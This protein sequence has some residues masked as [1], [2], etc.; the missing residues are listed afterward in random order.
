MA[1][2]PLWTDKAFPTVPAPDHIDVK[3]CGLTGE[4][5]VS[6]VA[7]AR[8]DFAGFVFF[9]PSPRH[10][11]TDRAAALAAPLR[12]TVKTVALT[13]DAD[14]QAF[15]DIFDRFGPDML[16]LHGHESPERVA[17]LKDRYRVPVMK[18]IPVREADDLKA[19]DAYLDV[20]DCILF[21]AKAPKG[22]TRPGGLGLSFDW[23]LLAGLD[24]PVPFMLSGGLDAET[25]A[26]AIGI[27][28]P[29]AVD[30]S[31][32]VESA[33]GAKDPDAIARF[34]AAVRSSEQ[35]PD[36]APDRPMERIPS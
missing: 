35:A 29:D 21:D 32:G 31:S 19:A 4:A 18:M 2:I 8:V 34:V 24:L 20:A 13:V 28:R 30:V 15:D 10:L 17:V 6:A 36:R 22:A 25:V 14:D 5:A 3:I 33:P 23:T 12:G 16:Q 26:T 9:P 27:A 7:A 11:D 1:P